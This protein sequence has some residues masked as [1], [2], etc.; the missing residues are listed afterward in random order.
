MIALSEG[1]DKMSDF[2]MALQFMLLETQE[3]LRA[4]VAEGFKD[5]D[6]T[7]GFSNRASTRS[8]TVH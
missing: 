2:E 5:L 1:G 4:I 3:I 7:K 8:C 6:L